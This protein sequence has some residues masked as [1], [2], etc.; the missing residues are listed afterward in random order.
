MKTQTIRQIVHFKVPSREVYETLIH[1]KKH[2]KFTGSEAR[3]S[4][5]VGGTFTVFDGYAT[6]KNVE[7][8]EGKKIVQT[9]RAEDWE[10]GHYSIVT[11]RIDPAP[12]GSKLT[13]TQKEVP[14]SQYE[15]IQQGW[16]DFYWTPMKEMLEKN[17]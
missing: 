15:A 11:F 7:L 17:K 5:K 13:F 2:A 1:S 8:V 6:G 12:G 10:S 3:I 14:A 4:R 9:W 16:R